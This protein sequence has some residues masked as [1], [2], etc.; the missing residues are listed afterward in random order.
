[1]RNETPAALPL[2]GY[3]AGLACGHSYAEAAGF[4]AIAV[5]LVVMRRAPLAFVCAALAGGVFAAA[6]LQAVRAATDASL[7]ELPDERFVKVVAPIDADW[8]PRGDSY[9]LRSQPFSANGQRFD[10]PLTIYA[11][12]EPPPIALERTIVAEGFVRANDRGEAVMTVKSAR[13]ISYAGQRSRWQPATW[14]RQLILRLRPFVATHPTQVALV[15]ALALGRSE[16]L[17]DAVRASYKRGG[18]YHLLVFS[19]LQIAFAA[20]AIAL[21]L[22]WLRAPRSSDWSLLIFALLAP[23]FIGP[24]AS[25]SRASI[26]VALYALSRILHR[27]TTLENLWCVAALLRLIVAPA[28]LTDAAFHLTYAG[29][30]ALMFVGKCGGG[31]SRPPA[32][33]SASLRA[34]SAAA[35]TRLVAVETAITP[36]TLFHFHQYALGGSLVTMLLTPVI[37]AMLVVSAVCCAIP[38]AAL[39][40]VVG[41]LHRLCTSINGGAAFAFGYF[42]APAVASMIAGY[43]GAVLAIAFLRGRWRAAAMLVFL[44]VPLAASIVRGTRD[45]AA[46]QLTVLDI[47]QGDAILLRAPDHAV[48]VDAGPE[49][50]RLLPMLAD[51]GVRR[52]DAVVL[53]HAHP[54]HCGGL[55]AVIAHRRVGS[56][57]ISPR[58]FRGDCAQA[59]LEAC[60]E[61]EVPIHLVRD[62][63]GAAFGP[64]ALRALVAGRTFKRAP[65]NNA[66]VVLRV[67]A[68]RWTALLTGDV[69]RDAE[70]AL[71]EREI[72]A[73]ILKVAH[74]GSRT[75]TS[76]S[77]LDAVRPRLALIS[78]GRRNTFGHP[79]PSVLENLRAAG[80]RT[81]RTDRSGALEVDLGGA[82]LLVHP[83]VDTPR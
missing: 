75:S 47:G 59:V 20:G 66:S 77:L 45:V 44:A 70:N 19:G 58:R 50:A 63:D 74:H 31:R 82:H 64:F 72:A 43:G 73:D 76:T 13:L 42:A 36:L 54:D 56:V 41:L 49:L 28:D 51:R 80:V 65:E 9:S 37:F 79:H 83:E 17:D 39:L 46:P 69:E 26:G 2:I 14:N 1:V 30:G 7:A 10:V 27:P 29:A 6:H 57:W 34:G 8:R 61:R 3:A 18:T 23:P 38:S 32:A 25:V 40:D 71:A 21:L 81:W 60:A 24:S 35:A 68:G 62:G 15:E 48:L 53:T 11:R 12:F 5:L 16:R 55:P 33:P 4:A 78:C 52:L 67:R 22:R